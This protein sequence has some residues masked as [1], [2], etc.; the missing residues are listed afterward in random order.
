MTEYLVTGAAGFIGSKIAELLLKRGD[1]VV[2]VDNL[3]NV[4]S[5]QLK[6]WRSQQLQQF[7]LFHFERLDIT[8]FDSIKELFQQYTFAAVMNLAARAGVRAS[9]ENPW[10]YIKTNITGT[11][12]LLELCKEFEVKKFI[13]ASTS[14]VYGQNEIPFSEVDLADF[15]LSPYAASKKGAE[16]LAYTYHYLY[17]IDITVLRYFTVYGPS[18]RPAMSIFKFI[19][20]IA[21]GLPIPVYGDGTQSRDF[22][23]IDD[24]AQGSIAALKPLGF[25][26]IN[27]GSDH[28]VELCYVIRLIEQL[29]GKRAEIEFLARHSADILST[30]ADI[31]KARELLAWSPLTSI[32]EGIQ[33]TVAWY[34]E[35][36]EFI[37]SLELK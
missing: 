11:L 29:L 14:S 4:Y 20:H 25:E 9:V 21:E 12:N 18:G 19:R 30:R 8:N 13:L 2:G 35:N 17:N 28:P 10:I 24:I 34:L 32:V 33:N 6:L 37:G 27:L 31:S 36:R 16:S 15:P 7:P 3:N 5:P 22:T 1:T 26:V 23:Y